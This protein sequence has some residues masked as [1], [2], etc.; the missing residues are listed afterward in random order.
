MLLFVVVVS[1]IYIHMPTVVEL[2]I[3]ATMLQYIA[4]ARSTN[5]SCLSI[6]SIAWRKKNTSHTVQR[7]C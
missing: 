4:Q 3:A 5:V 7:E 2:H 6:K 1:V